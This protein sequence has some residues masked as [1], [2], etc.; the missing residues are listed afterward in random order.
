M[1]YSP[2]SVYTQQETPKAHFADKQLLLKIL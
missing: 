2:P 1:H